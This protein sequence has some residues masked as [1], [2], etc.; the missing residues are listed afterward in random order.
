ML[1]NLVD[2]GIL[3]ITT[4]NEAFDGCETC[5]YGS[6]YISEFEVSLTTRTVTIKAEKMYEY[7]L[8][9]GY[10]IKLF[11][12]NNELIKTMTEEQFVEWLIN[13]VNTKSVNAEYSFEK[14][15]VTHNVKLK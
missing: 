13:E 2:G 15:K 3:N 6:S 7:P 5:D 9:E 8:S 14:F 1:V 12:N 10:L 4:D 11:V